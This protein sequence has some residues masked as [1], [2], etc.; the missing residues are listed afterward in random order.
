V[1]VS[2]TVFVAQFR[3]IFSSLSRIN[4]PSLDP[5]LRKSQFAKGGKD[6]GL[7]IGFFECALNDIHDASRGGLE[8]WMLS[9]KVSIICA[10]TEG[11]LDADSQPRCIDS[12]LSKVIAPQDN[13]HKPML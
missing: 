13:T 4:R 10:C 7:F 8:L 2:F 12:D 9:T 5:C 11:S 1:Q 6:L 3:L